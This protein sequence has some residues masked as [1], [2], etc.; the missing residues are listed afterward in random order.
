M[1]CRIC[2][3]DKQKVRAEPKPIRMSGKKAGQK[4][5]YRFRDENGKAWNGNTCPGCD[6]VSRNKKIIAKNTG[7]AKCRQCQQEKPKL[8]A[9]KRPSTEGNYYRDDKGRMWQ[10]NICPDC[11]WPA[12]TAYYKEDAD[13]SEMHPDRFF[14]SD[15]ISFRHCR[16]CD[17]NLPTSKYFYHN[18]CAPEDVH[19]MMEGLGGWE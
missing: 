7:I 15:P 16:K 12:Q 3:Q 10:G 6:W 9:E 13:E 18:E 1:L 17:K 8:R 5:G 19:Y 14:E 2:T 11:F 4:S